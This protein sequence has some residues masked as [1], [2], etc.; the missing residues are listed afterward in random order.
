MLYLC[1]TLKIASASGLFCLQESSDRVGMVAPLSS[2]SMRD[3][4]G[5]AASF[6]GMENS[7]LFMCLFLFNSFHKNAA[8]KQ[9]KADLNNIIRAVSKTLSSLRI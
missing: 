8:V 2:W 6:G 1:K 5:V 3:D 7:L 9:G 4:S